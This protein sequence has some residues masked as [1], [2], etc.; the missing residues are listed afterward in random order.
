MIDLAISKNG[1]SVRLTAERWAHI[2]E[3]HGELIELRAAVVETVLRPDRV[4]AGRDE[5]LIAVRELEQG[6]HL[7]VVYREG[8]ND[9]FIITAFVTRRTRSLSKRRQVWP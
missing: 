1:C 6:K 8:T 7:V 5:E 9:G 3:A 2:T 4:L